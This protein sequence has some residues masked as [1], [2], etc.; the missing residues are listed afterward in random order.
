VGAVTDGSVRDVNSIASDFNILATRL[1]P[2]AGYIH[3]VDFDVDVEVAGM[4]TRSGDLVHADQ[5]GA[6][7]IPHGIA[8][9]VVGAASI[10]SRKEALVINACKDRQSFSVSSLAEAIVAGGKI[11]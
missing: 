2:S 8:R 9:E 3:I 10:V 1:A 11:G 5:H 6:V 4:V 7:I